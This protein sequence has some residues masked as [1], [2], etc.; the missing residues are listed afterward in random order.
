VIS[1]ILPLAI[2]GMGAGFLAG[3]LGIG[4]GIVTI[5]VLFLAF[6][7]IGVPE[8]H[9]MHVAIATSL[10][11]IIFTNMSSVLAHHRRGGVDWAVVRDWWWVV[12]LGA[13][14]G[15]QF[16]AQLKTVQLVYFFA[17]LSLLVALRMVLRLDRF[18][19][20]TAL[21]DGAGRFVPPGLIGF[22]SAVMGIGGGSLSVPYMTLYGVPIHRA[23]GTAALLGLVISV[24]GGAGYL[25][26]GWGKEELPAG[27]AGFI[28]L[29]SVLVMALA[30]VLMAPIG[31]RVAHRLPKTVLSIV[32]GLFLLVATV[33]MITAI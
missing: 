7:K 3:L 33:R 28:H 5:P 14:A 13:V 20:G 16:A 2:A 4:G 32:F 19:L 21:P 22:F 11:T 18:S 29:P 30:A 27:M 8:E 23:V 24:A 12:G 10:V 26:G 6:R 25:A 31:A 17:G 15:S 9:L 1:F